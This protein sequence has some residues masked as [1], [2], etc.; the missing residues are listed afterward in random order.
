MPSTICA[1]VVLIAALC[2]VHGTDVSKTAGCGPARKV[3]DSSG[4]ILVQTRA[5]L[6]STGLL[7]VGWEHVGNAM[8]RACR[9]DSTQDNSASY[10]TL[11][12]AASLEDCITQCSDSG[13]CTGVEFKA[14]TGRCEL[15]KKAIGASIQRSGFQ[16]FR[17]TSTTTTGVGTVSCG[18]PST[19]NDFSSKEKMEQA[20]WIWDWTDNY[21]FKPGPGAVDT[22]SYWGY[23][24]PGDGT[25]KLILLG[26]GSLTLDYG[27]SWGEGL[28]RIYLNG[29][30][31]GTAHPN[32]PSKKAV[33]EFR[34]NDVLTIQEAP[35]AVIVINRVTFECALPCSSSGDCPR[36]M[37]ICAGVCQECSRDADCSGAAQVCISNK[38]QI[39]DPFAV[40]TTEHK[41][42]RSFAKAR[43]WTMMPGSGFAGGAQTFIPRRMFTT[44]CGG[45]HLIV[46]WTAHISWQANPE[47]GP[48]G[49][50]KDQ[51]LWEEIT[52]GHVSEFSI[53]DAG[54][55]TLLSD[56]ELV[57]CNEV[58]NVA[59]SA[60][61]D[62][63][64]ML[65][66]SSQSPA[67]LGAYDFQA[68]T[69]SRYGK[70]FGWY[71]PS[72]P[73][74]SS[75]KYRI[76][77]HMHLLEWTSGQ[78]GQTGQTPQTIVHLGK[79]AGG[80][81]YGHW[82]ISLNHN[83]SMYA[84]S[85]KTT[86]GPPREG[87]PDFNW[88]WHEGS[89]NYAINRKDWS[90]NRAFYGG[91][92]EGHTLENRISYNEVS[93]TWGTFYGT[94]A[95]DTWSRSIFVGTMPGGREDI[96]HIPPSPTAGWHGTGGPFN[97]VS[98]GA[99]GWLG[100][101]NAPDPRNPKKADEEVDTL[102]AA[103]VEAPLDVADC[104][105]GACKP[106]WLFD[107][108]AMPPNPEQ[109]LGMLSLQSLGP[110][111][112]AAR[113]ILGW[114]KVK[115]SASSEYYVAEIDDKGNMKSKAQLLN[116]VGWGEDNTWATLPETRCVAFAFTWNED[117]VNPY[118]N[119]HFGGDSG[120]GTDLF[121][122]VLRL[123]VI[124]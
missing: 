10:Y 11:V 5:G 123:T 118:G 54:R 25:I 113:L 58:G 34:N 124:C 104:K 23:K 89:M 101:M 18:A 88:G 24:Y 8:D 29:A 96:Y 57:F 107:L 67:E 109:K 28:V 51:G 93:D 31:M 97:M 84:V 105:D 87:E 46:A 77:D 92:G 13:T 79:H 85:L 39:L 63:V 80:W 55:T 53:D 9:G 69:E 99:K 56:Q 33:L 83:S 117:L 44:G 94:D 20:G 70:Q 4:S 26:S 82:D 35:T 64:A 71:V 111:G 38:C 14:A 36:Q 121:S 74:A 116:N 115:G 108:P 22:D 102:I 32:T 2:L 17:F 21:D 91:G 48:G 110:A 59:A 30:L 60:T 3:Q 27:N 7:P 98:R 119:S 62:V 40:T 16:C 6:A 66:R 112:E 90:L 76:V 114:A 12:T 122:D 81:N 15:W 41:M 78:A 52:I 75:E 72:R 73:N 68:E 19:L 100:I 103:L 42:A 1:C 120:P 47:Y 37:P 106:Q 95:Q 86:I 43:P 50:K 49:K 65:C 45:N 61:C